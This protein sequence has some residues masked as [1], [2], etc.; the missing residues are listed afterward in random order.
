MEDDE[1]DI[2]LGARF[3]G[4]RAAEEYARTLEEIAKTEERIKRTGGGGGTP[5]YSGPN[6]RLAAAEK[7]LRDARA[8]GAN[9]STIEDLQHRRRL[10]QTAVD[11]MRNPSD[12]IFNMLYSTR[13]GAGKFSPLLGRTVDAVGGQGAARGLYNSL[14]SGPMGSLMRM[15]GVATAVISAYIKTTQKLHEM[16]EASARLTN[17]F[18]NMKAQVGGS[19]RDAAE[20]RGLGFLGASGQ[21]ARSF[22]DRI[23]S[24]PNAMGAAARVGLSNARGPWGRM[25]FGRQYLQAIERVSSITDERERQRLAYLLGIEEEVAKYAMLSPG[26]KAALKRSADLN[27]QINDKQAQMAAAEFDA[28]KSRAQQAQ[29]AAKTIIGKPLTGDLATIINAYTSLQEWASRIANSAPVQ[30]ALRLGWR[31]ALS[32]TMG[33]PGAI[34]SFAIARAGMNQGGGSASPQSAVTDNTKATADLT[35]AINRLSGTVGGGAKARESLDGLQ[36]GPML[37]ELLMKKALR[38]G[39][40]G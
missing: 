8:N 17:E 14:S 18:T 27:A 11:R 2:A 30:N 31:V 22:Q 28:A 29:E 1:L 23:T 9:S 25:D 20:V 37:H 16:A 6:A 3:S 35:I 19:M 38:A 40:L 26:T 39:A 15:G 32:S 12:P 36:K 10:A 7:A 21:G 24:D 33:I 4:L 5:S 34:G 13:F